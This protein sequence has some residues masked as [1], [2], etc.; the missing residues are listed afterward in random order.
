[1]NENSRVFEGI[2]IPKELWFNKELSMLEKCI[3]LEIKSLDNEFHCVAGNEYFAEFCG[4]SQSAV[5]KAIKKLKSI[6]MIEELEFDGRHRKLRV[7]RQGSKIYEAG[8]EN[9]Q[10]NNIN[11]NVSNNKLLDTNKKISKTEFLGSCKK[12]KKENLYSTCMAMIRAKCGNQRQ[13]E[14]KLIKFLDMIS[15]QGKLKSKV[16]FESI[17]NKAFY[18]GQGES[19]KI[20]QVVDYSLERGYA[21][22]YDVTNKRKN[23]PKQF[24]PAVSEPEDFE[25]LARQVKER[26]KRGLRTSF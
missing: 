3:F 9:L 20:R 15:E 6:N 25:E 17:L 16:Q 18:Y 8:S 11:N 14:K 1:M 22:F 2:W 23:A 13:L 21:T 24:D 4:C 19:S 5:S 10:S 12:P 26:E 7:T